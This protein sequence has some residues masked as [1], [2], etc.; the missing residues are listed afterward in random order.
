VYVLRQNF[1]AAWWWRVMSRNRFELLL[2][3]W[4][5]S[6][7][8]KCRPGDPGYKLE[9]LIQLLVKKFQEVYNPGH[10]FCVDETIVPFRGR[11]IMRQYMP[12]KTHKYGIKL[13]LCAD[14]GYTWNIKLYCG[15]EQDAGASVPTNVVKN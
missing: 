14:N 12:Q 11:F 6:D 1:R 2:K 10:V 4:H 5:F 7:N 8:E 9:C 15:K 13:L 3:V